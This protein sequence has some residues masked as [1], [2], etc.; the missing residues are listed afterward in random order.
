MN[1]PT[2]KIIQISATRCPDGVPVLYA[3]CEDGSVWGYYKG[4][5][6]NQTEQQLTKEA[7]K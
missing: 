2:S 3:L 1:K 4:E 5:W 6:S 7:E